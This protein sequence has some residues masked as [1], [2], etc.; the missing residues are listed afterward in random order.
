[1]L[2]GMIGGGFCAR[3]GGINLELGGI[4][5]RRRNLRGRGFVLRG[6]EFFFCGGGICAKG[7]LGEGVSWGGQQRFV[8]GVEI[9]AWGGF[10]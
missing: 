3:M 2:V 6:E 5:A 1:M 8:L 4:C 9:S 7:I 10:Y